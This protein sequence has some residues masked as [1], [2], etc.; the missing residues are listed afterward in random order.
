MPVTFTKKTKKEKLIKA[1]ESISLLLGLIFIFIGYKYNH[2][3][4]NVGLFCLG[5]SMLSSVFVYD[6]YAHSFMGPLSFLPMGIV[7]VIFFV[8]GVCLCILS[9]ALIIFGIETVKVFLWNI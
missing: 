5:L 6:K 2:S 4:V 9:I 3:W 7:R 1:V 8:F